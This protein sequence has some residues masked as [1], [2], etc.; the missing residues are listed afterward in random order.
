MKF[1]YPA[2]I[3]KTSEQHYR[4]EFPDLAGCEADG[5]SLEDVLARARD[6][7]R[8]WIEV[9]LEEESPALPYVTDT[10]DLLPSLKEG[11]I[12]RNLCVHVRFYEGWD[13]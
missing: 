2:I 1:I 6:A 10:E 11:E 7:L 12:V 9:E 13:E 4:A 5:S 3:R 8:T